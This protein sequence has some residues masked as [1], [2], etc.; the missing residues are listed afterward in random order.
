MK[1]NSL[2]Y[3]ELDTTYLNNSF[4][5]SW[6]LGPKTCVVGVHFCGPKGNS[7]VILMVI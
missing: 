7:D 6:N 3:I 1:S 5:E 2:V 4:S